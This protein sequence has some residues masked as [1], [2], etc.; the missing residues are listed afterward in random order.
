M[1]PRYFS[2]VW[3]VSL[4]F[5]VL[6]SLNSLTNLPSENGHASFLIN[7]ALK[8]RARVLDSVSR[9]NALD[10]WPKQLRT[11]G[12]HCQERDETLSALLLE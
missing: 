8:R 11:T 4:D 9:A 12:R 5:P 3:H 10:K 6:D 7:C 2:R 1:I